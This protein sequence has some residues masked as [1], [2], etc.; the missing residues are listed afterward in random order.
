M[1]EKKICPKTSPLKNNWIK[2]VRKLKFSVKKKWNFSSN[3][4]NSFYIKALKK[5]RYNLL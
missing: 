1:I 4:K 3:G 2:K 5:E